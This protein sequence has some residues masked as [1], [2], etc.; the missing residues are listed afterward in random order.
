MEIDFDE[1]EEIGI[2]DYVQKH[3]DE[4]DKVQLADFCKEITF[5]SM[6][7]CIKEIGMKEGGREFGEEIQTDAI[8]ELRKNWC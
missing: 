6:S 1:L 8:N 4:M 5:S 3:Y 7:Y 2:Y